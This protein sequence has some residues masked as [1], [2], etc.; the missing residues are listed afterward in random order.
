[1]DRDK[2][3]NR[4]VDGGEQKQRKDDADCNTESMTNSRT[5]RAADKS[6]SH[7]TKHVVAHAFCA[8]RVD[9]TVRDLQSAKRVHGKTEQRCENANFDH[10][11]E[12]GT[13][14]SFA[15]RRL[16]ISAAGVEFH[17]ASGVGDCFNTG[18]S[19]HDADKP[20]PVP[21]EAAVQRLQMSDR[22]VDM[23]DAKESEH[24]DDDQSWYR[25]QKSEAAGVS[26]AKQV[27]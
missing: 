18:Q 2:I 5:E 23:R 25:N 10:D 20:G 24:D 3:D 19:E 12:N 16:R 27:E 21:P 8:G 11:P 4:G 13:R 26:R 14:G 9:V 1:M 17:H 6:F 15:N 22:F 7:V